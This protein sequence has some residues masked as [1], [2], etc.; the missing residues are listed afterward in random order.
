MLRGPA[1]KVCLRHL[2]L[3]RDSPGVHS[4]LPHSCRGLTPPHPPHC[5]ASVHVIY[6]HAY[7]RSLGPPVSPAMA[8]HAIT[9]QE[10][11]KLRNLASE[12]PP[13]H[14]LALLVPRQQP[15]LNKACGVVVRVVGLRCLGA[16]VPPRV[17]GHSPRRPRPPCPAQTAASARP[18]SCSSCSTTPSGMTLLGSSSGSRGC[19]PR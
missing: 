1:C 5:A 19:R 6:V 3:P 2:K 4:L 15:R 11:P 10:E 12:W 17:N 8:L 7:P 9:A 18:C 14:S 13:L 16:W